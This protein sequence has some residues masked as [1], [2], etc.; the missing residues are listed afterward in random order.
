MAIARAAMVA[1][2][3]SPT[4]L[5]RV[6]HLADRRGLAGVWFG[7]VGSMAGLLMRRRLQGLWLTRCGLHGLRVRAGTQK[8]PRF[9]KQRKKADKQTN[10]NHQGCA[11]KSIEVMSQT[12]PH[13]MEVRPSRGVQSP[14]AAVEPVLFGQIGRAH[15]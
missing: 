3:T 4:T 10:D 5:R 8:Q 7:A 1:R 12:C 2:L 13:G 14:A 15:V 6:T 11:G 9:S